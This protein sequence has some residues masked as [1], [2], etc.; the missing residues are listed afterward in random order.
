[1]GLFKKAKQKGN[2]ISV[3]SSEAQDIYGH[4]KSGLDS[5]QIFLQ[6][7]IN[8]SKVKIVQKEILK[9][10]SEIISRVGGNYVLEPAYFD[11]DTEEE[12]PAVTYKLVSKS[13]LIGELSSDILDL[14]ILCGDVEDYFGEYKEGRN[15]TEFKNLVKGE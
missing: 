13:A 15:F 5:T 9:L 3:E 14:D 11:A 12:V 6:H 1:M 2:A 8:I 7:G 4:L 10:E